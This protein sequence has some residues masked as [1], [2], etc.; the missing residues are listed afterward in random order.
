MKTRHFWLALLAMVMGM[1]I[2]SVNA[3]HAAS[4]GS[5][6]A[7]YTVSPVIGSNQISDVTSYFD[8]LVQP[9]SQQDLTVNISNT[10]SADKHLRVSLTSAFTQDNGQIGY[11]PNK[12]TDASAEYYLRKLGSKPIN[13][14]V[15]AGKMGK[16]TMK[17]NIPKNGFK[18]VLLGG[19]YVYDLDKRRSSSNGMTINNRFALVV[20]VQ[21][22]TTK[23]AQQSVRPE[24][25]LMSVAPGMQN[26]K[27]AVLA[28]IQNDTPTFFGQM[29][30]VGKVS[31]RNSDKT[32][33][34]TK[35]YNYAMAPTSHFAYGIFPDKG[36]NPGDYTL[37]LTAKSGK[38]TW[39]FKKNF[40]I[41]AADAN[42]INKKAGIKV[43]RSMPWW[44]WGIIILLILL[45]IALLTLIIVLLLKRRKKDDE[46]NVK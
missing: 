12:K 25:K 32:L 42:K 40:T 43:D 22:Q 39:H 14:T 20:G 6:G 24:L 45:L 31:W 7:G 38:R 2:G 8:L 10:T 21:L 1:T 3:V 15:P 26:N 29:D 11:A 18:G 19:I 37:D 28:T 36:L 34:T 13:V 46:E 44:V 41:L 4:S 17:V 27:P 16:V 9:G 5:A 35:Q 23:L 33:F 30:V